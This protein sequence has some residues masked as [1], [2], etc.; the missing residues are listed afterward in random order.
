[1]HSQLKC[2]QISVLQIAE[3]SQSSYTTLFVNINI[4][5]A[6][7]VT[8]SYKYIL[9]SNCLAELIHV[10]IFQWKICFSNALSSSYCSFS[11]VNRCLSVGLSFS[12]T[13][14]TI[15]GAKD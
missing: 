9:F 1:M 14:Q 7:G 6:C 11:A 4:S 8:L 15:C 2:K 13:Q 10:Y 3:N 12:I 5:F